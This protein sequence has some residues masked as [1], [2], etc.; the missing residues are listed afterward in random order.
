MRGS[1][2]SRPTLVG[3]RSPSRARCARSLSTGRAS[4]DFYH[5]LAGLPRVSLFSDARDIDVQNAALM[6]SA[7]NAVHPSPPTT[8][9]CYTASGYNGAF[10]PIQALGAS[11][12]QAID[13]Y[14]DALGPD[15]TAAPQGHWLL[16]LPQVQVATGDIPIGTPSNALWTMGPFGSRPDRPAGTARPPRGFVPSDVVPRTSFR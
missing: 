8:L 4:S 7:N 15:A 3:K 16:L 12:V 5:L 10:N 6:T 9:N 2:S 11:G 14:L 13:L 1:T